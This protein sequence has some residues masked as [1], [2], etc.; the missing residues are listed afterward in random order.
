M[1][2]YVKNQILARSGT[3]MLAQP[4]LKPQ[5]VLDLLQ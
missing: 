5:T 4:N 1:V 2:D 3:S